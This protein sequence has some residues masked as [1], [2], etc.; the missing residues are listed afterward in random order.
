MES[1]FCQSCGMPLDAASEL[2]G[3]EADGSLNRDFCIYCY[4]DGRFTFEGTMEEMI[5]ICVPHVVRAHK[6]M[7]E[8]QAREM[9]QKHFPMLKRWKKYSQSEMEEKM[10]AILQRCPMV[11]LGSVTEKGY[12]RSCILVK[13]ANDGFRKIYVATGS[14]SRKTGHFK[15][16]PKAGICFGEGAD[17]VTLTGTI[18]ILDDPTERKLY[19]QDWMNEHFPLGKSDPEFCVLEFNTNEATVWIDNFFDTYQ[20]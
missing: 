17:G 4:K 20:Y 9:M 13:V 6:E 5:E 14:S 10:E 3:T 1:K 7:S 12:P 15:A 19:W 2:Y 11:V 8:T 16:N 18:R